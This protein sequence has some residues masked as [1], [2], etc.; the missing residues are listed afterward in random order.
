MRGEPNELVD[1]LLAA[2]RKS[3]LSIKGLADRA[4]V[5]YASVHGVVAERRDPALSTAAKLCK[6]LGLRLVAD[7]Q[8]RGRR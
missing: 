2:F 5:P 7:K 1:V 6:V 8:R 4:G 3:R